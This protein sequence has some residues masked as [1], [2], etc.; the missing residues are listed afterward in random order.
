MAVA[1]IGLVVS[2]AAASTAPSHGGAEGE[3]LARRSTPWR[4]RRGPW[5]LRLSGSPPASAAVPSPA[6][7]LWP[8]R[9]AQGKKA[10]WIGEPIGAEFITLANDLNRAAEAVSA[11]LADRGD[12]RDELLAILESITQGVIATDVRQQIVFINARAPELL[13]FDASGAM[14]KRLW[15]V[16]RSE[17]ILRA[18]A[19]VLEGDGAKAF[20]VSQHAGRHLEVST[21]RFPAAGPP[22]GLVIVAHDTTRSVRYQELRK[23]FVA[24]VSHELRT[25]LTVIK[26]FTETLDGRC[27]RRPAKRTGI[28]G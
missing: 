1:A 2:P 26:G 16:L 7:L 23:E 20:Q 21:S 11:R 14:G 24:N 5:Y 12:E 25:P 9:L 17:P 10:T 22:R 3:A 4:E 8:R 28:P 18:A 6:F 13:D 15:E 19:E 27:A